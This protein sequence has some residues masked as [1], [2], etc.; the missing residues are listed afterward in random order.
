MAEKKPMGKTPA[1]K[2]QA[3]AKPAAELKNKPASNQTTK[4]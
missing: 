2:P 3:S 1:K 4:R